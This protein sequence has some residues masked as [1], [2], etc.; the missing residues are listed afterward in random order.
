LDSTIIIGKKLK[1]KNVN[2][3]K[4]HTDNFIINTFPN[5]WVGVSINESKSWEP[6]ITTLLNRN[7]NSDSVFVDA[8]SNYGWHSIKSSLFC[9]MV[10]SFEPQKYIH[11][12]QK[13]SI[14]ENNISNIKLFNCG[15]G[16]VNEYKEMRPIKY[17][18]ASINMG[19]LS[20]GA[21]GEKIE[22]KTIDSLEISKVDFIKI[23]V[24][25]Y[26]KYVLI[27][28]KNTIKNSKPIIIIEMENHQ[29]KRFGYDVTELFEILRSFG[30]YIYFLDYRYPSDHV[31]VHK[32]NLD[33]FI[34]KNSQWI[35]PLTDSNKLNH[36]LENYVTEKIIQEF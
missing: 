9:K 7:F 5:D 31:C 36:N 8:G 23:D 18:S 34:D 12:L 21:G 1:D 27:G 26:E 13:L 30:Y 22:I 6:H 33:K 16:D 28:S 3:L 32:D 15:L 17:D 14:T 4:T 11:D 10:Y 2:T 35:K 20:V 25:G 19:D 24:Q 29:L